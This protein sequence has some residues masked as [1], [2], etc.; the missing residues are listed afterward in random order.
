MRRGP[1]SE[2]VARIGMPGPMP[3]IDRYSV[4]KPVGA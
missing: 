1:K 2:T 3:P 4:G